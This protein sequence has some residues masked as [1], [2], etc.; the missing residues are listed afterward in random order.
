[1]LAGWD[2][3]LPLL[4]AAYDDPAGVTRDFNRNLLLRAN[5][6]LGADF[7]PGSFRHAATWD[8]RRPAM[9]SWLVSTR[10]QRVRV[11]GRVFTLAA[12]ERIHTEISCKLTPPGIEALGRAAGLAR[13]APG[14]GDEGS[15]TR[16]LAEERPGRRGREGRRCVEE[17]RRERRPVPGDREGRG[18]VHPGER[19]PEA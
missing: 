3:A 7:D 12:G 1:M 19:G 15:R 5:R 11:G 16:P 4:R 17:H 13:D 8:P 2:D 6:D 14:D 9:E 18:G 10:A